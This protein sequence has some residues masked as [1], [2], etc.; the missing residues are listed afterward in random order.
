MVPADAVANWPPGVA[1]PPEECAQLS[2]LPQA[3]LAPPCPM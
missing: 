1:K 2:T 3:L